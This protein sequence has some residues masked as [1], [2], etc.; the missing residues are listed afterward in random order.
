MKMF[1]STKLNSNCPSQH[2]DFVNTL[3]TKFFEI[4]GQGL[5]GTVTLKCENGNARLELSLDLGCQEM[6]RDGNSVSGPTRYDTPRKSRSS[7][8]KLKRSRARAEAYQLKKSLFQTKNKISQ[9]VDASSKEE[10]FVP[11]VDPVTKMNKIEADD[12]IGHNV[13]DFTKTVKSFDANKNKDA[14][15]E[16]DL[17]TDENESTDEDDST[18]CDS[19]SDGDATTDVDTSNDVAGSDLGYI[20]LCENYVT[21]LLNG[22]IYDSYFTFGKECEKGE[23]DNCKCMDSDAVF[24]DERF[25]HSYVFKMSYGFE[26]GGGFLEDLSD[27]YFDDL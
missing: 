19:T 10:V 7:P 3:V 8:S 27:Y 12:K 25:H 9:C 18:D 4:W 15:F 24:E 2:R 21:E 5:D 14:S 11:D 13:E 26:E 22:Q 23:V 1:E 17:R 20:V 16:D 6:G